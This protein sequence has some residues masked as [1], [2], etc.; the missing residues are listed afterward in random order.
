MDIQ[1]LRNLTTGL[2][3]TKVADIYEDIEYLTGSPRIMTHQIPNASRAIEP[4]LKEKIT[5]ER[6]FDGNFYTTHTGEIDIQPMNEEEKRQMWE[7]YGDMRSP[8][9]KFFERSSAHSPS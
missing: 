9:Q 6:F 4:W 7:R 8:L 1:R 5:D 3:H 2:L